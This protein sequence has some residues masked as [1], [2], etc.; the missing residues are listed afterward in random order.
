MV[1]KLQQASKRDMDIILNY[2]AGDI[3]TAI[4]AKHILF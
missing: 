4:I 3:V 2:L 1:Q